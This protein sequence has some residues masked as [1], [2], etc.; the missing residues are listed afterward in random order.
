LARLKDVL[1]EKK[2]PRRRREIA[3]QMQQLLGELNQMDGQEPPAASP[4]DAPAAKDTARYLTRGVFTL[5]L[6]TRRVV[7][8]NKQVLL[9]P[10]TFDYLVTLMRHSPE[11]VSYETL[12]QN[13][14]DTLVPGGSARDVARADA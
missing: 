12:V 6:H 14:R 9:A 10:S 7:L 3:S 5:D 2:L 13:R 8:D 11:P 1:R 4:S